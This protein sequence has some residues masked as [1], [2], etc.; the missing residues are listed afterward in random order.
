[1]ESGEDL[2]VMTRA[3]EKLLEEK[4]DRE[5]AGDSFIEEEDQ[6]DQVLLSKLISQLESRKPVQTTVGTTKDEESSSPLKGERDGH[7]H[8]EENL[9]AIAKDIKD[10][11][12]QNKVTHI[13]LS[14]LIILTL[15]WQLSQYSMIYLMKDRLCHPIRSITGMFSGM[16]KVKIRPLK[17]KLHG[18][19]KTNEQN[20][21]SNGDG[22][23]IQV[24]K[25]LREFGLDDDDE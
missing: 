21:T 25:L 18:T 6:D 14:T 8:L 23:N 1:M 15:T 17:N 4:R 22:V 13:L 16:F 19:S 11:K 3:I 20:S 2:E 5:S 9:E 7:R 12:R 10:V 24:P